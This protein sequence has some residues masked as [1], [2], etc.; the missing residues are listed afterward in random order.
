MSRQYLIPGGGFFDDKETGREYLIPGIGFINEKT[1][2]P[3]YNDGTSS[4]GLV[5][6]GEGDISSP[7]NHQSDGISSGGLVFGGIITEQWIAEPNNWVAIKDGTYRINGV[8]YTLPITMSYEGIGEIAALKDCS[9]SPAIANRYRYDLLS[10]DDEQNIT[11]TAGTEAITP[12]MPATPPG[13]V[14][15]D[16]VLRYYGQTSII[17]ADIGK[18]YVAP[19]LTSLTA[20][21]AD[22]ELSWGESSAII[23]V[24]CYDQYGALYTGGKVINAAIILG[25]GTISP[26]SR[27]GTASSFTFTYTRG[28]TAGDISPIIQ[29]SSPTGPL[30][31]IFITLLDVDGD[32]MF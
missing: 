19:A 24:S 17:Q 20:V 27:S 12:V 16:H 14:K 28:G 32:P 9:A 15:L 1:G 3:E 22:N 13:E 30:T 21:A 5:F 26:A 31:A 6:G 29:F 18:L 8:I 10:V 11:V 7:E 23:T 25:N 2:I 4:G